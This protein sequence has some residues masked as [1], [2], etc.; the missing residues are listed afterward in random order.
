M[1]YVVRGENG[2][3]FTSCDP[4]FNETEEVF[5]TKS[6]AEHFVKTLEITLPFEKFK[7]YKFQP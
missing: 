4:D 3:T 2:T 5:E 1:K 7:A 6:D